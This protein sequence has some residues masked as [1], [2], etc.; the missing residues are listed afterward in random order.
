MS[1]EE[2][3]TLMWLYVTIQFDVWCRVFLDLTEY[4]LCRWQTKQQ[5]GLDDVH[6]VLE[7]WNY[8]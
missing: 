2:S 7:N 6:N 4:E 3:G 1:L 8:I 5:K